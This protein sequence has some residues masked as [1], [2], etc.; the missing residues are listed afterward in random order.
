MATC[1]IERLILV[2]KWL[3]FCLPVLWYRAPL[4]A[5]AVSDRREFEAAAVKAD[6]AGG[7]IM[8]S[9]GPAT[10]D[11]STWR[12][13]NVPLALLVTMAY[14]FEPY[15]FNPRDPCCQARFD[16]TAR[17]PLGT[18]REEFREMQ[19]NLLRQRFKLAFHRKPREMTVFE[20]SLAAD[21]RSRLKESASNSSSSPTDLSASPK[22]DIAQD[23]CPR[24][25]AGPGGVMQGRDGCYRWVGLH[26][27]MAEIVKT[28]SFYL[29]RPVVDRTGLQGKYDVDM[30]WWIDVA[31]LE[32]RADSR[33]DPP[34]EPTIGPNGPNLVEAVQDQL[35]LK[36]TSKKGEGDVVV[37]DHVEKLPSEN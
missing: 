27:S 25:L 18:T 4:F 29:G 21:K 16:L 20:L 35:G 37:V 8:C 11:P 9:G 36:L 13:R 15:E 23:G 7:A 14:D 28:L 6:E 17:L 32:Q 12:C 10:D 34:R 33:V 19:Q 24:F 31:G 30:R 5:Q 26:L 22:Y 1:S 2:I 3:T